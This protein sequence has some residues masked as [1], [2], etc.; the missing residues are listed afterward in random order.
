MKPMR[1]VIIE[2]PPDHG[3]EREFVETFEFRKR[4]K[5]LKLDDDDLRALPDT[6]CADPQVGDLMRDTGGVRKMR[7]ESQGKSR[8]LRRTSRAT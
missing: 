5:A 4:W 8:S 6:L 7:L 3:M 2:E 1:K